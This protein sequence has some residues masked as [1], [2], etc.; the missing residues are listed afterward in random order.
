MVT[1]MMTL[2]NNNVFYSAWG[3]G[4]AFCA[5]AMAVFAFALAAR[6]DVADMA[7]G[8]MNVDPGRTEVQPQQQIWKADLSQWPEGFEGTVRTVRV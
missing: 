7:E 4:V 5:R 6:A 2:K 1:A 3:G 8:W